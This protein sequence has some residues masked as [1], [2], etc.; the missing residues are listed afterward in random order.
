MKRDW[1]A[2]ATLETLEKRAKLL[3]AARHFFA[4]RDVLEVE[5]PVLNS[6]GVTDPHIASLRL[7]E[8][9]LWLRTSPEYHMKRL[10]A[11]AGTDIYQIA[12]A[13]R[14]GEAGSRHQPEFTLAEWY[15]CGFTLDCM[16]DET[17][18]F[19]SCLFEAAGAA[20]S[21]GTQT[22]SYREAFRRFGDI[23]PEKASLDELRQRA[24]KL[25][26][27]NAALRRQLADDRFAWLDF[28]ASHGVYPALPRDR[29]Q[30]IR[31]YPAE[32]AMLAK[33]NPDNPDC[34][35]RF[36]VFLNGLELANGFHEL[37]DAAE[38]QQ[39]FAQDNLKREA[40]GLPVME[41]DTQLLA[42][43]EHGLPDCCG[44]AVG[45]DR[46]LM[47]AIGHTHIGETLSF[48]PGG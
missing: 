47:L 24:A 9:P 16:I 28:I 13:F 15:R 36:E 2:E 11:S 31:D 46:V 18:A 34:A 22:H 33:F 43:L 7:T 21:E 12:K 14:A 6:C 4:E 23:D 1:R 20:L 38:Q 42:A 30:V 5:T 19:I 35:E 27:W 45:L 3:Q 39:R 8:P 41:T 17:T 48:R 10:L 26:G 40:A 25:P 37:D 29:L 32:Q 44:V